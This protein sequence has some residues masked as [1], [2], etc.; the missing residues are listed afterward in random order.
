MGQQ[1]PHLMVTPADRQ[2]IVALGT[3]L[4]T[5]WHAACTTNAER[6]QLLQLV[7]KEV[8]VDQGRARGQVWFQ[9][10]W[11]TGATSEHWVKRGV[12]RYDEYADPEHVQKRVRAL[13]AAPKLDEEIA[14]T[15]NAE[16]G[17]ASCRE[18][19]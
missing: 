7:I 10:N 18:R 1:Q 14:A 5:I 11:Q 9:I 13:N 17:R 16:I 19:G 8:I 15:L 4:P 3:D 2:A 6:K 12:R